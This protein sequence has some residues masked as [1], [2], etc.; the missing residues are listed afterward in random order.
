M[1]TQ[2][3]AGEAG[4]GGADGRGFGEGHTRTRARGDRRSTC[5]AVNHF[6][7]LT[8]DTSSASSICL[9]TRLSLAIL[10]GKRAQ[11]VPRDRLSE[12]TRFPLRPRATSQ[13]VPQNRSVWP[14]LALR[15]GGWRRPMTS[16]EKSLHVLASPATPA[17]EED[18]TPP[19][20]AS[21]VASSL[22]RDE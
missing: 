11:E 14:S 7:P 16:W 2:L 22:W 5:S 3:S 21:L 19:W 20:A 18:D 10:A 4:P 15:C 9:S 13:N 6:F 17:Q 1:S 8:G 12:F